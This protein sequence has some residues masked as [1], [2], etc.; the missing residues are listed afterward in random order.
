MHNKLKQV[1]LGLPFALR[2]S[3]T[4]T[5]G[6]KI[7]TVVLPWARYSALQ[8]VYLRYPQSLR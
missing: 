4:S 3:Q 5:L 2:C 7:A 6:G 1:L 8:L